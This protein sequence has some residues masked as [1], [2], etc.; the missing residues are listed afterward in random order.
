MSEVAEVE[1]KKVKFS[2]LNPR[3][4]PDPQKLAELAQSIKEVG[5]IQPVLL[6]RKG[7]VYE[8]VV[9]ERRVKAS[10]EA[11]L[12]KV[13]AIIRD[14]RDDQALEMMLIENIQ[15]EDLSDVEKGSLV[16][17]LREKFPKKYPSYEEIA[18][19]VGVTRRTVEKWAETM[20][21][22]PKEMHK[23]IAPAEPTTGKIPKGKI[24]A[25]AA[26]IITRK[27]KQPEKAVRLAK[28]VARRGVPRQV[29]TKVVKKVS[30]EP[31]KPVR[32]VFKEVVEEA[33][34]VLPFSHD[35]YHAVL[36]GIKT[37]TSRKAIDPKIKKGSIV[38]ASVTYF[39]DLEVT[40]AYKK[41][42]GDFD[43][44]DTMREGGYD[45]EGFKKVWIALHD[46]WNPNETVNVIRFKLVKTV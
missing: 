34:V 31:E 25:E 38:H 7:E 15:R 10:Q 30:L 19:K 13:P 29:L 16:T 11:G 9:G 35:H 33:P 46:E 12:R 1:L 36:K 45:L 8:V 44:E 14:V 17:V 2:G 22:V 20:K 40:D 3:T 24:S 39:A 21:E 28:E 6:R 4:V 43:E 18:F 27:V 32:E 5:L 23:L 41:K 42:L 26:R 37:Q